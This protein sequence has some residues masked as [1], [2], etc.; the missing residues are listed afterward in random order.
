MA[1]RLWT[2]VVDAV[3]KRKLL[4]CSS[5]IIIIYDTW[6]SSPLSDELTR[7]L[8]V[9]CALFG[10]WCDKFD[11]V[12]NHNHTHSI[13]IIDKYFER[14]FSHR[15]MLFWRSQ[16]AIHPRFLL[17]CTTR[18]R[19]FYRAQLLLPISSQRLPARKCAERRRKTIVKNNRKHAVSKKKRRRL[20]NSINGCPVI[21]NT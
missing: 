19:A 9:A 3:N 10:V 17:I 13:K 4:Y 8:V 7:R 1:L 18:H 15:A 21:C 5:L 16:S 6:K 2:A 11:A 20:M 14:R 12:A